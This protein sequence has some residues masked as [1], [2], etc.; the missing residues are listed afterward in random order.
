MTYMWVNP[1]FLDGRYSDIDTESLTG[2]LM[3][4]NRDTIASVR[5]WF[6]DPPTTLDTSTVP[7]TVSTTVSII[8][9]YM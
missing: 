6:I 9:M 5:L 8:Y 2:D 4:G 1:V 7:T 3:C